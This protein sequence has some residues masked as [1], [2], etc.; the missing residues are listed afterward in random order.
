MNAYDDKYDLLNFTMVEGIKLYSGT[1]K[2]TIKIL[3]NAFSFILPVD[4]LQ[5]FKIRQLEQI[6]FPCGLEVLLLIGMRPTT[7]ICH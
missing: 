5:T 2:S 4:S 3:K 1:S 7:K 6:K